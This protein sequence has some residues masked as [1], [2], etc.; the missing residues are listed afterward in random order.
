MNGSKT[1]APE[2]VSRDGTVSGSEQNTIDFL[3]VV[4]DFEAGFFYGENSF[5]GSKN[6]MNVASDYSCSWCQLSNF[7]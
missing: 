7:D 6:C 2:H 5:V 3:T 1:L 4:V